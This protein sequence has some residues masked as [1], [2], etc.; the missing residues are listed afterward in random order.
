VTE[1]WK[2]V[3]AGILDILCGSAAIIVFLALLVL[4]LFIPAESAAG[5]DPIL[6]AASLIAPGISVAVYVAYYIAYYFVGDATQY[7]YPVV[8]APFAILGIL[9]IAGGIFS[10]Q[11]KRWG[12]SVAGTI[13]ALVCN[14]VPGVIAVILTAISKTEF[15]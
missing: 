9:A 15:K 3:A 7:F 6:A 1:T 10:I 4:T 12:W 14:F 11:R 8:S 2:P 5:G 13:A